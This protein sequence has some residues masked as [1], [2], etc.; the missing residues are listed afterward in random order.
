MGQAK[1][2]R[3]GKS[4]AGEMGNRAMTTQP[5]VPQNHRVVSKPCYIHKQFFYVTV[6]VH[7][8]F[9]DM[10]DI[11]SQSGAAIKASKNSRIFEGVEGKVLQL[12]KF[13][14]NKRISGCTTVNEN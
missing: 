2:R 10:G 6:Q 3:Q 8:D 11:S 12:R 14:I 9:G 7:G 4:I 13:S 1:R 5:R